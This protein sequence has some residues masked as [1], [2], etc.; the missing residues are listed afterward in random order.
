MASW[1]T[2]SGSVPGHPRHSL[3]DDS[4]ADFDESEWTPHDS[5]YGAAIPVGGCIPKPIRRAIEWTCIAVGIFGLVYL[6]ITTSIHFSDDVAGG[7]SNGTDTATG[8][9]GSLYLDDDFYYDYSRQ[10]EDAGS[11][12]GDGGY[13]MDNDGDAGGG[14]GDGAVVVDDDYTYHSAGNDGE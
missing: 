12:G 13:D 5:S 6:V 8:A 3:D 7:K 4:L 14:G 9:D 1:L 10:Y 11:G 2:G